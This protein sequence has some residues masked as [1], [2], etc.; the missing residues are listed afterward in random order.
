MYEGFSRCFGG[1]RVTGLALPVVLGGV[2]LLVVS[3][4][5]ARDPRLTYWRDLEVDDPRVLATR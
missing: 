5:H 4:G 1:R 3:Q 2:F